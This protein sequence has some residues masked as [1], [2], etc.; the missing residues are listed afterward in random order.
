VPRLPVNPPYR[1]TPHGGFGVVRKSAADGACGWRGIYPCTHFGVDLAAKKG[2]PVYAPERMR[3]L[4]AAGDNTTP[5]LRGFGPGAVKAVGASGAV[6]TL[7][8]LDPKWWSEYI[9]RMPSSIW[10]GLVGKRG[11]PL[12]GRWYSEGEQVGVIAKDHV[13]WEVTVDRQKVDPVKWASGTLSV[14]SAASGASQ[15]GLLLLLLVLAFADT[16]RR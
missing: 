5:G 2:T 4:L 14:A 1:T 8:H 16:R 3:V 7:G 11:M 9:L 13:H 10:D 12:E 6:H 15:S